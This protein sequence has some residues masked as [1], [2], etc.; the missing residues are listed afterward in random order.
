MPKN[1]K[2]SDAQITLLQSKGLPTNLSM[3][4]MV[5]LAGFDYIT[6][7]LLRSYDPKN[8]GWFFEGFTTVFPTPESAVAAYWSGEPL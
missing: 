7:H 6:R 8:W 1:S 3:D 4:E 5:Q 2:I